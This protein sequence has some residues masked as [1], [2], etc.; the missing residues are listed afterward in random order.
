MKKP[1]KWMVH[2]IEDMA[3]D[4]DFGPPAWS[5]DGQTAILWEKKSRLHTFCVQNLVPPGGSIFVTEQSVIVI[6]QNRIKN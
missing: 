2:L 6:Q 4:V 1:F 5:D 3:S